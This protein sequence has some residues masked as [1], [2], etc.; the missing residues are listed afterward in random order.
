MNLPGE[1]MLFCFSLLG[2]LDS[3]LLFFSHLSG[4]CSSKHPFPGFSV[5]VLGGLT[6]SSQHLWPGHAAALG[7]ADSTEIST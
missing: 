1:G 5:P 6:S 3:L 7:D 2:T 4:T